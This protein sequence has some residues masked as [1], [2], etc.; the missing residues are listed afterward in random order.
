MVRASVAYAIRFHESRPK[1]CHTA[2]AS[3]E[4]SVRKTEQHEEGAPSGLTGHHGWEAYFVYSVGARPPPFECWWA[5]GPS[6]SSAPA[7]PVT[8]RTSARRAG[9]LRPPK[10]SFD[11]RSRFDAG[12]RRRTLDIL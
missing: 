12:F 7:W 8:L 5:R 6:G 4:R 11:Q 1:S 10:S 3:K 2:A 9:V